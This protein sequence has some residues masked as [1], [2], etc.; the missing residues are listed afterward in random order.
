MR[1]WLLDTSRLY[2]WYAG[3][4]L[5]L[6]PFVLISAVLKAH[7][8]RDSI[9]LALPLLAGIGAGTFLWHRLETRFEMWRTAVSQVLHLRDGAI[10]VEFLN[11]F[12][13]EARDELWDKLHDAI[14]KGAGRWEQEHL[15]TVAGEWT[16]PIGHVR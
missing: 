13:P 7:G 12:P 3:V 14:R 6:V 16:L 15:Q 5:G 1:S 8:L 10:E 9:A 4:G 11:L 2:L